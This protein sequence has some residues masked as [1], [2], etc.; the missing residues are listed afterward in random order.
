IAWRG[1]LRARVSDPATVTVGPATPGAQ[2]RPARNRGRRRRIPPR[3][4]LGPRRAPPRGGGGGTAGELQQG[5]RG[6]G[7]LLFQL[8]ASPRVGRE[9]EGVHVRNLALPVPRRRDGARCTLRPCATQP[10]STPSSSCSSAS[11]GR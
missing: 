11:S 1:I 7:E 2:G 6:A 5:Q 3:P 9:L 8:L 10:R 4:T